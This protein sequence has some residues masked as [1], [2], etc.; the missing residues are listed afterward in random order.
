MGRGE[1]LEVLDICRQSCS[2]VSKG[3][4]RLDVFSDLIYVVRVSANA[5]EDRAANAS[6][7]TRP[8]DVY[9]FLESSNL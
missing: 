3:R 8:P 2:K 9:R 6:P 5:S 7:A 4:C 1:D